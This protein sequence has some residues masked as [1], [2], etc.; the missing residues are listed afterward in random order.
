VETSHSQRHE[1]RIII[2]HKPHEWP[3]RFINGA[4]IKEL[5]GVDRSYGVWQD[6]PGP[7]DPPVEDD[8]RVDLSQPGVEKFFTGKKTTTEG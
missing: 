8:Q 3:E 6:I 2:D 7:I 5:A 1:F 4:Q